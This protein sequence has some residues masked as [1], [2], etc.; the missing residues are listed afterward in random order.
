MWH[1]VDMWLALPLVALLASPPRYPDVEPALANKC[2]SCH[3]ARKSVN[4]KAQRVFEMSSYPFATARPETLLR[5]LRKGV[6]TR[7]LT[8]AERHDLLAWL[9]AGALDASGNPPIWRR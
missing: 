3:D 4:E 2:A 7:N 9:D 6:L 8:E 1:H 5:D